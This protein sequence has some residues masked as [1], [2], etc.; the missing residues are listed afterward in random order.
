MAF[1]TK[2]RRLTHSPTIRPAS[3]AEE[4]WGEILW[5]LAILN[6][7]LT[8]LC[9]SQLLLK[10][11]SR[12]SDLFSKTGHIHPWCSCYNVYRRQTCWMAGSGKGG[13][14]PLIHGSL[15]FGLIFTHELYTP[16]GSYLGPATTNSTTTIWYDYGAGWWKLPLLEGSTW[17]EWR[18]VNFRKVYD[19]CDPDTDGNL[20]VTG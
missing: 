9:T 10:V 6:D 7:W 20:I 15:V 5:P 13:P 19:A 12:R 4:C 8:T 11:R 16:V 2:L 17:H 1:I 3:S 18:K 14:P